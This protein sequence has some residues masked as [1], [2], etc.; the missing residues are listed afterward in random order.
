MFNLLEVSRRSFLTN[1]TSGKQPR[2]PIILK[3]TGSSA[4]SKQGHTQ[5]IQGGLK[6]KKEIHTYMFVETVLKEGSRAVEK[7]C[8]T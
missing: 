8:V 4:P 7:A 1:Q 6:L 2:P 3:N 5:L